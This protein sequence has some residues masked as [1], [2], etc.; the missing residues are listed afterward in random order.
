[1][2]AWILSL[3]NIFAPSVI[4]W[5]IALLEKQYPG[6]GDILQNILDYISNHPH[7]P[8]AVS[9]IRTVCD[10]LDLKKNQ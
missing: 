3:L 2:P 8:T 9:D 10:G 6:L 4:K 7:P 5:A 1:M